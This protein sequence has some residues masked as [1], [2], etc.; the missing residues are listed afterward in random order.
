MT[1]SGILVNPDANDPGLPIHEDNQPEIKSEHGSLMNA[2]RSGPNGTPPAVAEKRDQHR[3][4][5]S[6]LRD[7]LRNHC[8]AMLS[9]LAGTFMFLFFAYVIAQNANSDTRVSAPGSHPDQLIM[10]SFGF[11]FSLMVACFCTFRISGG[12]LNPAVTLS[13]ALARAISPLRAILLMPTQ[14][15]AGIAAAAAADAIT[16]GPLLFANT[17]REDYSR[18]RGLFLEMFAT[19]M[20]CMTVLFMAV[21]K[22]RATFIAPMVIGIALFIG[23]LM[24]VYN[25]GAGINPARSF[26]PD[27][28]QRSFPTY[29]WIYWIGPLLGS[30]LASLFHFIMRF[31]R[32][33]TCNPGQDAEF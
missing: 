33:E 32:Y 19:A 6:G 27:V 2:G 13:L 8:I 4:L 24:N 20:L 7:S 18:T 25:T 1:A 22:A 21:E 30:L 29:H 23:H 16:P 26:G 12:Q 15:V 28:V 31:L 10:I 3:H 14:V 9:E 17:L 5:F 11:G